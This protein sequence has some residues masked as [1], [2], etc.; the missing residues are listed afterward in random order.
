MKI[1]FVLS[2]ALLLV[3]KFLCQAYAMELCEPQDYYNLA[4]ATKCSVQYNKT[5]NKGSPRDTM[6]EIMKKYPFEN[7][8]VFAKLLQRKIEL[9]ENFKT[10]QQGQKRTE[11]VMAALSKLE[12]SKQVLIVQLE[13]V[14]TATRDNWVSVR[15][16]TRK[17]LEETAK[18]LREIE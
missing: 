13:L 1:P 17:A 16:Q 18:S 8:D 10:Q 7:K 14:N 12:H 11:K 15:D 2:V 5:G 6:F 9:V 4:N 3:V